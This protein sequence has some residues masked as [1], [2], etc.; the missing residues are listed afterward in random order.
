[1]AWVRQHVLAFCL[2]TRGRPRQQVNNTALQCFGAT[3]DKTLVIGEKP[4]N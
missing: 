1:M 2:S 3:F 4:K